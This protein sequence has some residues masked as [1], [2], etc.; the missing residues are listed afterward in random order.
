MHR[1]GLFYGSV[2][3][4][5]LRG[6]REIYL[7]GKRSTWDNIDLSSSEEV[8]KLLGVHGGTSY[9]YLDVPSSLGYL[10]KDPKKY[11]SVKTPFVGLVHY[12]DAV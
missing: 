10:H 7:Y 11:V 12:D 9:N 2:H 3:I 8:R 5:F 6:F 4:V 1:E